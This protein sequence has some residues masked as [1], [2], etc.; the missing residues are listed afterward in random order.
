M[1]DSPKVLDPKNYLA[2]FILFYFI[3]FCFKNKYPKNF[4]AFDKKILN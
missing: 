2:N 1:Q 3:L 4:I